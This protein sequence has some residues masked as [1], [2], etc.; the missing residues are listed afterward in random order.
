MKQDQSKHNN[1]QGRN[2]TGAVQQDT[3]VPLA[4]PQ[5][6]VGSIP[7]TTQAVISKPPAATHS[8]PSLRQLLQKIGTCPTK[9]WGQNFLIDTKI[10]H[11]IV[12]IAQL[13]PYE[14]AL[15]IGPGLGQ[16]TRE[17]LAI[18][19]YVLAVE[20]DQ[21]L[22]SWLEQEFKSFPHFEILQVD[23]LENKHTL[24]P[25]LVEKIKHFPLQVPYKLIANLPYNIASPLIIAFLEL[26]YQPQQLVVMVQKEVAQRITAL[27]DTP[28]YG[29]LTLMV[30][31]HGQA[32]NMLDL[33]PGA[34]YPPPKVHSSVIQIQTHPVSPKIQNLTALK[35]LIRSVFQMRRKT[36]GHVL[37]HFCTTPHPTVNIASSL[38]QTFE[39]TKISPQ[40]RAET[41]TLDEFIGLS[42]CLEALEIRL[43]N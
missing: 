7:R 36:L 25:I 21:R 1:N 13:K 28:E 12:E 18:T 29:P 32:K 10:H 35:T 24:N 43:I 40:Q 6:P 23:A 22:S 9:K 11:R 31:I 15:E 33:P 26:K 41:L 20:I 38:S 42:N 5:L 3:G 27:S 39:Q 14:I 34:F 17:M 37:R 30:Q 19:P 4:F 2:I 8:P 16:L